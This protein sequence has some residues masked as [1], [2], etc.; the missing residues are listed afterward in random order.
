MYVHI[1]IGIDIDE[2][3]K[4]KITHITYYILIL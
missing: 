1:D 3:I 4:K 2:N